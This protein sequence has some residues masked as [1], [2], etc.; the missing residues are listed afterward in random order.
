MPNTSERY[1][2]AGQA[3]TL[4]TSSPITT[5]FGTLTPVNPLPVTLTAFWGKTAGKDVQ[6]GWTTAQALNSAGFEVQAFDNGSDYTVL[7]YYN[8]RD[9]GAVPS[10]YGHL[11][12]NAFRNGVAVRYYRLRQ[13]D[14]DGKFWY[15]SVVAVAAPDHKTAALEL[16]PRPAA[17]WLNIRLAAKDKDPISVRVL[18][19]RGRLCQT[20]QYTAAERPDLVRVPVNQLH[21][22]LY[23]VQ[24]ETKQSREQVRFLKE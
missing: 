13:I 24:V 14:T 10:Y 19:A 5:T 15:S 22:G 6:L 8:G 18:D 23:F 16:W 21:R 9:A 2:D 3:L 4:T 12:R 17:D 11:D 20:L 7:D 1:L